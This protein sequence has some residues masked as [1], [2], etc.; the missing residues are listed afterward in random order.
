[1]SKTIQAIVKIDG[2]ITHF[3][4]DCD[5]ERIVSN[6]IKMKTP[7]ISLVQ[8]DLHSPPLTIN[9]LNKHKSNG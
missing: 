4:Y 8:T 3:L 2:K 1:M 9:E 7:N 6:W 5:I